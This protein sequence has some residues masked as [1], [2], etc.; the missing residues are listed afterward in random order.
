MEKS[1]IRQKPTLYEVE[2]PTGEKQTYESLDKAIKD[3]QGEYVFIPE[4]KEE[5]V[6]SKI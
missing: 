2:H 6:L 3:C 4:Q 5:D 1:I